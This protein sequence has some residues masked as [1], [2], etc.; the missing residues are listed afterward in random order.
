MDYTKK[1]LVRQGKGR[2]SMEVL[3]YAVVRRLVPAR[4]CPPGFADWRT[5][6][7]VAGGK[8]ARSVE[9][10]GGGS[11]SSSTGPGRRISSTIIFPFLPKV[12]NLLPILL[13]DYA[14]GVIC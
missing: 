2:P 14:A 11:L 4:S 7:A 13:C 8:D 12:V 5:G 3:G 10:A 9:S 1:G 6:L